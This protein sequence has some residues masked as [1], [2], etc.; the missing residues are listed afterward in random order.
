MFKK[1]LL[2][3]LLSISIFA[4]AGCGEKEVEGSLEEIMEKIYATIP[5]EER[6]MMLQNI[7][8]EAEQVEGYIGTNDINYNEI[9]VS[10]SAVGSI[11][12]SVVLIRLKD[13]EDVEDAKTKIKDNV[14]PDKWVC[15]SAEKVVVESRGNLILLVMASED[16]ATEIQNNFINL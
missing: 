7:T 2:I 9:L 5:Q 1:I 16:T 14:K 10:E 13:A 6:P 4:L 11:A 8:P 15:V 3:F 12:H